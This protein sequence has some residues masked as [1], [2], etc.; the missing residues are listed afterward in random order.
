MRSHTSIQLAVTLILAMAAARP[1]SSQSAGDY[2]TLKKEVEDLKTSQKAMQKDLEDIKNFLVRRPP[3]Q[4]EV[5]LS[6]EGSPYMGDKNAKVTLIEFSDYQCPFCARH[7][8]KTLPQLLTDYVKTGK[9]KYVLRD[10]PLEAMHP[11][12]LKAAEAAHCAGEQGKYWELHDRLLMSQKAIDPKELPGHAK[13]L[14]LDVPKLEQC[15]DS[16]KYTA[17]VR[18][19]VDDGQKAGVSGTPTFFL[20]ATQGDTTVKATRMLVGAQPYPS[21]KEA[22]DGLLAAQK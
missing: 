12:A 11:A 9:V 17:Q 8:A 19:D 10:F 14:G 4:R 22:I 21:F 5:V 1:C 15:V 3:E 16:G 20:G 13:A 6:I 2:E 7:S 18:K